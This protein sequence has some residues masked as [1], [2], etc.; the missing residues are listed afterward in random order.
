MYHHL[1][2]IDW[3]PSVEQVAATLPCTF[4]EKYPTTYSIIDGSKNLN[5]NSIRFVH[6]VKHMECTIILESFLLGALQMAQC[7]VSQL[8]VGSILNVE[9]TRVSRYTR[10]KGW[11]ICYGWSR[12]YSAWYVSPKGS[13]IKHSTI[14]GRKGSNYQ[15]MKSSVGEVLRPSV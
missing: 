5:W 8:Y 6:A 10:W 15:Q 12:A 1:K 2:E 13:W 3:T 7:H 9:L 14:H 11:C 4:Q